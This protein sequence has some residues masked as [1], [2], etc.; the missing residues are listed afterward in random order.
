MSEVAFGSWDRKFAELDSAEERIR[1]FRR[2]Q[3]LL[4]RLLIGSILLGTGLTFYVA[5]IVFFRHMPEPQVGW[6]ISVPNYSPAD[7][8]EMISLIEAPHKK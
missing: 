4:R 1:R 5:G 3:V 2:K 8:A 7:I 6:T